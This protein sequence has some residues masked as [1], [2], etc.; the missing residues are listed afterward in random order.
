MSDDSHTCSCSTCS[1]SSSRI[2]H[3]P[4]SSGDDAVLDARDGRFWEHLFKLVII[5]AVCGLVLFMSCPNGPQAREF[6]EAEGY[7]DIEVIGANR[8]SCGERD[9]SATGFRGT[10]AAGARVQGVVC[11][12]LVK[13][14]T[15]RLDVVLQKARPE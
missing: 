10:T 6:L 7:A 9:I 2:Y 12:G 1:C 5:L 15:V 3:W 4:P 8:W 13:A 11:C 14:C